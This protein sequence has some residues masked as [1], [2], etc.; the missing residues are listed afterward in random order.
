M[1]NL[2]DSTRNLTRTIVDELGAAI[3]THQYPVGAALPLEAQLCESFGA[4]R[5]VLREAIKMLTA[6]G[7]L[8]ARQ[9]K[10]T[11]VLPESEWSLLDPDVLRWILGRSF[12][13]DLLIDF[14]QMRLAIEPRAAALAAQLASGDQR[15]AI[16]AAIDRMYA[17]EKGE[18]D[19]LESDI[20]F[21]V[22]V[23]EASNN[24][25]LQQFTD[26]SEASLRF[27]IRQTNEYKGVTK[28]S[29]RDHK[30]VLDA[31]LQGEA[32][33]ASTRM[34][35]LIHGALELLQAAVEPIRTRA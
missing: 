13:V 16:S 15:K 22:A 3:V 1:A 6:K 19:P 28:A 25:F 7:L 8:V 26:L 10:G 5:S 12:S 34:F 24:R 20:A 32:Q 14:T 17:A 11:T 30:A 21:H 31:I 2:K 9:R 23:L 33:I 4:S 29:A 35:D 18:D 27:S